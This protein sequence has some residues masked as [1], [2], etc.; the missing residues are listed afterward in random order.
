[1]PVSFTVL[2]VFLVPNAAI[3]PN[4]TVFLVWAGALLAYSAR[5]LSV[6]PTQIW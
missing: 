5:V 2:V 4:L 6:H 1:M 3:L